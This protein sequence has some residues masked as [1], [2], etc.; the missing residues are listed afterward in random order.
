MRQTTFSFLVKPYIWLADTYDTIP[1]SNL[2]HNVY[3]TQT[4]IDQ[5]WRSPFIGHTLR[6]VAKFVRDTPNPPKPIDKEYC[7]VLRREDYE[8]DRIMNCKIPPNG[9]DSEPQTI[10]TDP[11]RLVMVFIGF[12]RCSWDVTYANEER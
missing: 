7:A 11:E 9:E 8:Q 10:V 4:L 3:A 5:D 2:L 1:D 12:D 6:Q